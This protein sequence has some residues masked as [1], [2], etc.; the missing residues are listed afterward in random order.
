MHRASGILAGHILLGSSYQ[1]LHEIIAAADLF[2]TQLDN[3]PKVG[4][5]H[6]SSRM[7]HDDLMFRSP[8]HVEQFHM[9]LGPCTL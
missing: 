8:R 5:R 4:Q 9:N 3:P 6:L 7:D 1:G 2:R